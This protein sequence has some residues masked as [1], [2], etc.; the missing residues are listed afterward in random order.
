MTSAIDVGHRVA[1]Q[2]EAISLA[3]FFERGGPRARALAQPIVSDSCPRPA[4]RRRLSSLR[5]TR[6]DR[7]T[8]VGSRRRRESLR[9]LPR[10]ARRRP[11]AQGGPGIPKSKVSS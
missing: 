2:A 4:I 5:M 9:R 10:D 3:S 6:L 11:S 1:L 8:G 7:A